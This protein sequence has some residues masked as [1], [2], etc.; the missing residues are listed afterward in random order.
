M[1]DISGFGGFGT[2]GTSDSNNVAGPI[3]PV[4]GTGHSPSAQSASSISKSEMEALAMFMV[5]GMPLLPPPG[6]NGNSTG[7][8]S[9]KLSVALDINVAAKEHD[10]ISKMWE[11][12][13]ANIREIADRMKKDDIRA[14]TVDANKPGPKSSTEYF[15]YLMSISVQSRADELG[16][17][18][19]SAQF[20]N[21]FNQWMVA[22][23]ESGNITAISGAGGDYP[24]SSFVAGSVASN[25]DVI[26]SSI[27][28]DSAAIGIYLSSSPVADALY[29]VGPTSGLPG[30]YQAA[31]A[32]VAA[33]LNGGA[34]AKATATTVAEAGAGKTQ[35]NLE[36]AIN[37][38]QQVMAIVTKNLGAEDPTD[39]H[40]ASQN[41]LVRLMLSAMALNMVYRAAYGGMAGEEFANLLAGN[42][43][44]LP[45]PIK[46]IIGQLVDLVNYYLNKNPGTKPETIAR[47]LEYVDSKDSV[48]SMLE[49][50]NLFT[51]FLKTDDDVDAN[52]LASGKN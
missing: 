2:L 26:R 37:Y 27:G 8:D 4:S 29:A 31:A 50:S 38:A 1:D 46:G 35:P 6:N 41:D 34:L 24:S 47:L 11:S 52:R 12:Y 5:A 19:V 20:T 16:Q 25:P 44:D 21:T 23:V 36:F 18:G 33:L 28:F 48:D 43:K 15:T 32:M 39:P 45:D 3:T 13:M 14:D 40:R 9:A 49:T 42:A 30:D 7:T 51:S 22:P 17:N 10:I